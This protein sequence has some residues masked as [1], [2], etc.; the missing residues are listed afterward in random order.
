[1]AA[2][3][4]NQEDFDTPTMNVEDIHTILGPES[5][6][7]GKLA[8]EGTVRID[9]R[10]QGE[11]STENVLV[12]G[13]SAHV[14]ANIF[15][16]SIIINGEVRGD[17]TATQVV[18]IHAPGKLYGNITTPQLLI[19]RGVIFDGNCNMSGTAEASKEKVT[20]LKPPE[21]QLQNS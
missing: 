7:E 14:Q 21:E 20:F 6:F 11:I 4:K 10:F 5:S 3:R 9:G 1:M 15:V 13:E 2:L 19:E 16:G 12:I 17:I 18:E 8:F